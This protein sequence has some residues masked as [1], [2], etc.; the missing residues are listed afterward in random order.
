[1]TLNLSTPTLHRTTNFYITK[2]QNFI[3]NKRRTKCFI[4]YQSQLV[5]QKTQH[6]KNTYKIEEAF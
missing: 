6:L 4:I 3:E 1:M 5:Q 2:V